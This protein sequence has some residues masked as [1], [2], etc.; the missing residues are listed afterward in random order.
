MI[1][2]SACLSVIAI[3]SLSSVTS[4]ISEADGHIRCI[5]TSLA[6]CC[7]FGFMVVI[8]SQT[9]LL[10]IFF[11]AFF[12]LS[13]IAQSSMGPQVGI[14][15]TKPF[16]PIQSHNNTAH[17]EIP[18]P[19]TTQFASRLL[20]SLPPELR[21]QI[22]HDVLE[23]LI[24]DLFVQNKKLSLRSQQQSGNILSI[25]LACRQRYI[26]LLHIKTFKSDYKKSYNELHPLI[27]S[28]QPLKILHPSSLLY[29][30]SA[31]AP[32]SLN[33]GKRPTQS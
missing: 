30:A 28:S 16:A 18:L 4:R 6:S 31:V 2:S 27:Y 33:S 14:S 22:W 9:I 5:T 20:F 1:T 19:A 25:L 15:F 23:G 32:A 11:C 12:L 13:H 8:S 3:G 24:L 29:F 17:I 10:V 26:S 7:V 21:S